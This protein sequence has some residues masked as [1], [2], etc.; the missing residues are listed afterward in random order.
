MSSRT[1]PKVAVL[2]GGLSAEREVSL[3]TGRE[4]AAALRD[5]G[6]E[7]IEVDC[8]RDLGAQRVR[9][10]GGLELT[11]EVQRSRDQCR[12]LF[13]P[14]RVT[15]RCEVDR[16]DPL[17]GKPGQAAS[18]GRHRHGDAVLVVPR[19]RF[20]GTAVARRTAGQGIQ[21][22][23]VG[24]YVGAVRTYSC[25][26]DFAASATHLEAG[27][28]A[29]ENVGGDRVANATRVPALWFLSCFYG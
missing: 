29:A 2:M 17:A 22:K 12:A 18:T 4:C 11:P 28:A 8:G 9:V 14:E 10:V 6:F 13:L 23:P 19:H 15:G 27:Y 5:E 25:H 20:F 24:W 21:G 7:V 26:G 3:S 1:N 16:V